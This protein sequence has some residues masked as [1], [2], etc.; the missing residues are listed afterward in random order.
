[1]SCDLRASPLSLH[2]P[3]YPKIVYH[4]DKWTSYPDVPPLCRTQAS[5]AAF[6]F[7]ED[8]PAYRSSQRRH[9]LDQINFMDES[10][11]SS[12]LQRESRKRPKISRSSNSFKRKSLLFFRMLGSEKKDKVEEEESLEIPE[13]KCIRDIISPHQSV[14]SVV[15]EPASTNVATHP[16]DVIVH[17]TVSD[18]TEHVVLR[19]SRVGLEDR[20]TRSDRESRP[21]T[22]VESTPS[23]A[24]SP[25]SSIISPCK[26]PSSCYI[27][28]QDQPET[29]RL[30]RKL[31]RLSA[32]VRNFSFDKLLNNR[33]LSGPLKEIE[34]DSFPDGKDDAGSQQSDEDS[35]GQRKS[36]PPDFKYENSVGRK[37]PP[38]L[39]KVRFSIL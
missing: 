26:R 17:R 10:I 21:N 35:T 22:M 16:D 38:F 25:R 37:T 5:R 39:R 1:M 31:R 24:S 7:S 18:T 32:S 36:L 4:N 20:E 33:K 2:R 34:T 13:Q 15:S 27:S 23:T 9:T 8:G 11:E 19:R 12:D 3:S 29:S 28:T 30:Q 14:R 6:S